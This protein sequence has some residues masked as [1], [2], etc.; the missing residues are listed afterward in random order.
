MHFGRISYC[1]FSWRH[2]QH[3][4]LAGSLD[5]RARGIKI[6]F[7][8]HGIY[9]NEG[10]LKLFIRKLFYRIGHNHLLYER[11]AKQLMIKENFKPENL[12][13]V[14]NSL[15][16]NNHIFLRNKFQHIEKESIFQ[17][18]SNPNLQTLIFIGRLTTE[19]KLHLLLQAVQ[20]LNKSK[21]NYNLIIIGD[22]PE[23]E[24]LK[25]NGENGIKNG[26]LYFT[27][28]CYNEEEISRYI[29]VSDLV[30]RLVM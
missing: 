20:T 13:V 27:G 12:Y 19:K 23:Y 5:L 29:F 22:G 7:W 6:A 16:Y 21:I 18:F 17:I 25:F 26:W 11:R 3:F 9:G 14:F 10:K 8:G 30:F 15:D 4:H 1:D 2:V 28:S 24:K